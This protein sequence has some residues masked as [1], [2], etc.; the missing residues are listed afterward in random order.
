[1]FRVS[2]L[3]ELRVWAR[4]ILTVLLVLFRLSDTV[5]VTTVATADEVMSA[6]CSRHEPWFCQGCD[7]GHG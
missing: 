6:Y 1:M 2:V 3:R 4:G 7:D 5:A